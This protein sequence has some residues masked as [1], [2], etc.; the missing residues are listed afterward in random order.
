MTKENKIN[1]KH[2]FAAVFLP[3]I[4]A[5]IILAEIGEIRGM[6]I[7][8]VLGVSV[9]I[10]LIFVGQ[11][12][13]FP[14]LFFGF[15]DLP[16]RGKIFGCILSL[17]GFLLLWAFL[18]GFRYNVAALVT[19]SVFLSIVSGVCFG[20]KKVRWKGVCVAGLTVVFCAA[21]ILSTFLPKELAVKK[22]IE[23]VPLADY[24][25]GFPH[26]RP[27]KTLY[28][29]PCSW[30]GNDCAFVKSVQGYLA[31]T[32]DVQLL[33]YMKEV[34]RDALAAEERVR[35]IEK[36]YPGVEIVRLE[37]IKEAMERVG[38]LIENYIYCDASSAQ[39]QDVALNLC[40]RYKA[41]VVDSN[42]LS[43]AE[44]Y[45]WKKAFDTVGKDEEWLISSEYFSSLNKSL[46]FLGRDTHWYSDYSDYAIVSNG[47]L[48]SHSSTIQKLERKLSYLDRNF[49]A[50]GGL[51]GLEERAV[52][53]A[54]SR[55]GGT[56][57][58]SSGMSNVATLSSFRLE[59]ALPSEINTPQGAKKQIRPSVAQKTQNRH[60]VCIMLSDGDN[61]RFT[62]GE[63]LISEKYFGSKLRSEDLTC[64][65]GMSG[66]CALITPIVLLSYYDGMYSSEDFVTQLGSIG[67]VL[68]SHWKDEEA[69]D[70]VTDLLVDSMRV[71]D[72]RVVEIMDD[73]AFF[74]GIDF[75]S[76]FNA[77]RPY[78]DKYTRYD[79]IDGCL[80]ISFMGLYAGYKG[81][82]C[83][84]NGKPVVSARYSVWNGEESSLATRLNEV[85]GIAES[86]NKA[87]RD[88]TSE[89][90][91]SFVIVHVWSGLD[92]DGN[93]VPR[94]DTMAAVKKLVSLLDDDVDV[95]TATEFIGRIKANVKEK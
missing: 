95:V 39:S 82:M 85:E 3:L 93:L 11:A 58:F 53:S 68:P 44:E 9:H 2:F 79:Q 10:A 66:A 70:K 45:G 94:G 8:T 54:A 52:V 41:V 37:G 73:D 75:P 33:V 50:I 72:T 20:Y 64:N 27:V 88:V 65:Y 34:D 57:V 16:K 87:S 42:T 62:A 30:N 47:W 49:I 59:D 91:Y 12:L 28:V 48:M 36:Y 61:M 29:F 1:K 13:F 83:W 32:S 56:F 40:N 19:T 15:S 89:D 86:I 7:G 69:F 71:A 90:S 18:I 21:G 55:N 43:Y 77:L 76:R 17:V 25:Q 35:I 5:F 74:A 38:G 63:A 92:G 78:F 67:Y 46:V 23:T 31:L 60:T 81:K 24:S 22:R 84:S 6:E 80:C 4:A 14:I 51:G 26:G